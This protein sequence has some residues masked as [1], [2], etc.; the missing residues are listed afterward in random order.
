MSQPDAPVLRCERQQSARIS[1][2]DLFRSAGAVAAVWGAAAAPRRASASVPPEV[3]ADIDPGSL[4]SKLARRITMGITESELAL[5]NSLGYDG[6]LEYHLDHAAIP[7]DPALLARLATLTTLTMD[8][9]QLYPLPQGQIINELTEAAILRA[10]MS[11]RQLFERMVEFWTDHFNIDILN[12][13][14]RYLKTVDDR[15]VIRAHAL[16]TFPA[17]LSASAHSPAMLIYLDNFSSTAG[18]PN[19][20]YAR[21]LMELHTM[22]ASGGYTQQDVA[23]VARC[24]TGWTLFNR[25]GQP[26]AGTFRFNALQHDNNQKIVLGNIIPAGGGIQ[27]GLTVL[28]ILVN[29]PSTAAF[30]A[31]K[32]CRWLLGETTP[33]SII[34]AVAATYTSTT[35]D[36]KSMIRTAL[37]P[38]YLADAAPRYKRPFHHFI[39]ALRALPSTIVTTTALR[40]QLDAAGHR[41]FTWGTPDGYPDSLQYWSGLILPRWNFGASLL[42]NQYNGLSVNYAAF[43]SGLTTAEQ[44]ADRINTAMFGGEM[45]RADRIRIRDYLLPDSPTDARRR[46]AVG[47]AIASPSFQWY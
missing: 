26:N 2:R 42:Q 39:S 35:G 24:F 6:Y 21:E 11:K 33:Q 8:P 23:E 27:D 5:A 16:G 9:I 36:I 40:N 43:F 45:S 15:E 31:G 32:L 17:L 34:D 29:H 41:P 22:G 28:D 4:V 3:S 47:L 44:M 46:E 30:I 13:D 20:N 1:R 14:D 10:V 37:T 25:T 7:E 12:G 19:E 18:N 38:N